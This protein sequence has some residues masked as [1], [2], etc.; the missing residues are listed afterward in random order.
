M[1]FLLYMGLTISLSEGPGFSR[2]AIEL[3]LITFITDI[4]PR[5]VESKSPRLKRLLPAQMVLSALLDK[6]DPENDA[7]SITRLQKLLAISP[8]LSCERDSSSP[9]NQTI[10]SFTTSKGHLLSIIRSNIA[11]LQSKIPHAQKRILLLG[12]G[13]SGKVCLCTSPVDITKLNSIFIKDN[14]EEADVESLQASH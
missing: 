12:C 8:Q 2:L 9:S 4:Y 10:F 11:Y 3:D 14:P 5:L 6:L 1:A 7:A 13:D